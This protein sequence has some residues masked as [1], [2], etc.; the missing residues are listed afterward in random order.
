MGEVSAEK[1]QTRLVLLSGLRC[2]GRNPREH[3]DSQVEQI[4][5][6]LDHFGQQ[7][8]I[9]LASNGVD[10]IAGNGTFLAAKSLGWEK[11][12]AHVSKLTSED[13]LAYMVADNRTGEG[14]EWD[15]ETL[16]ELLE[17]LS[18]DSILLDAT[19]FRA[20]DM[21]AL[22]G[23]SLEREPIDVSPEAP[24]GT[25]SSGA[26]VVKLFFDEFTEPLFLGWI[27]VLAVKFGT[28]TVTE[29]VAAVIEDAADKMGAGK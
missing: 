6:S 15:D 18:A 7:K 1:L 17:E 5:N 14:S 2:H 22:L 13:A 27:G 10:I 29:T 8:A 16:L 28:G 9:V 12:N 21:A 4:A 11:I 23:P 24:E 3:D 20:E 19:G 26:R 25:P